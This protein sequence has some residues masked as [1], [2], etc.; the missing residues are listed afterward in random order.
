MKKT[1]WFFLL[2]LVGISGS[3]LAQDRTVSGKVTS[4]DDGSTIPGVT[5]TV[6]G[7]SKGVSTDAN[8][9][10]R[11]AVAD[12]AT[13]VFTS[14]GFDRKEVKVGTQ[15]VIDI[16]LTSAS[17]ALDEVVVIGYGV[18]KKSKLSS[19]ITKIDGKD[20]A[21]LSGPSF[22]QQ[23][24]GRAAG[25]QVTVG[26]GIVGQAPRIRIRGTNS[27]TSGGSPLIVI[28][29]VPAIDGNQS[30][31]TPTN[32][33][34]DIDPNDIESTEILKDGAA[35]AIYGSRA[36][37]GVILIT[38]KK[39][40]KG[41]PLKVSLSAQ[42]GLTNAVNRLDLLN[43]QQF[44]E[45]A[46]EKIKNAG[47]ATNQAFLD[48]NNTNTDWQNVILRQG[49]AQN[50]NVNFGGGTD[51]TNYYFSLGYSNIEGAVVSNS[52]KR[53]NF[54]SN[55]DHSFNKVLSI[56]TKLQITRTE[57]DGLNTGSNALSGNLTG[58]ARLFP[59]VPALDP[60]NATGFNL[61]PDGAVLG[62]GANTRGIDNNYTNLAF[63]LANNK[64]RAQIGRALSTT[65]LQVVPF[66]GLILKSQI[67]IDYADTRSFSSTDPRHGD[68]RGS[69]G[70]TTQTSRNVTRWNW[71]NTLNFLKDFGKHSFN[72]T[73]GLEYQKE[74]IST[75][76]ANA[77]NF[78]DRFFQAENIISGSFSVPVVTGG[79][80]NSGFDSY[81]G[82]LMYDY[83]N[84]YFLTFSARNDGL[85]SLPAASR[86]GNF[87]GGSVA[88]KLSNEEFYKN[89]G[90]SQ[91]INDIKLRGSYAQVG[92]TDIG[93]FPYLGQ[94][95]SA[96]YASQN[97][98]GFTQ[99][100]NPGLKWESSS[101]I[102]LGIDLGLFQNRM[103]LTAEYYNNDVSD[104]IL[105]APTPA[106]LGVPNNA[107]A[108]NV[109]SLYNRGFEFELS[110]EIIKKGDFMWAV[111]LNYSTQTNMVT[112]LNKGIDGKDQS[113]FPSSYHIIRVGEPVAS[114]Y[115]YQTAGVNPANGSP[116]FV[117]GDGRIVQRNGN[118]GVYSFYDAANPTVVTNTQGAALSSIDVADGGDRRVLGNTNPTWF[119]GFT[120]RFTWKGID[121]EIFTRFSGGNKI[122]NV[123]RQETLLNQDFN[124]NSTE[125][126]KRW[127]AEGQITDVP[128]TVLNGGNIINLNANATSRFIESGDFIRIQNIILGYSLPKDMLKK[129]K[130]GISNVRVFGQVQNAFTFTS[131][132][133]LDP[134]LNANGNVNQTFGL[135][136][137]TNP[138]FRVF[139]FG[140]NVGF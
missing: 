74:N 119:G 29:G 128:R 138:Q 106:S 130:L 116:L 117:K 23:L 24:A 127:T 53:Y 32:P 15:S 114:L 75:F 60:N 124:N 11:I 37:N 47:G 42:Y 90:I 107:I 83:D 72:A 49:V 140:V 5:V 65:Y 113:I 54:T 133:G 76:S 30:G 68:G 91:T 104:L 35:T 52:Q 85:S 135:D 121:L 13:L 10:Y 102:N 62:Q 134:E 111:D 39:G 34:A 98:V 17:S 97:G 6:K 55:I 59:N 36:T 40:K 125:I 96:Q 31:A 61:S 58:A 118:T 82:R 14:I 132:K 94:F 70:S 43:A 123:T 86:R 136:F 101:Q 84:K 79:A 1:L 21:N 137:N 16:V 81:F 80:V 109:G 8:G 50:Y 88:Y 112:G 103:T 2:V 78:S 20:V 4:S 122:M 26:S 89:L 63:V 3:A 67:G 33:L 93:S 25:T 73:V 99:A 69:N 77:S 71:Q 18:Q 9:I 45:I 28:D 12:Q 110:A 7:T 38:T 41:S 51:K 115:G 22:D 48:A 129:A 131:Y 87:F 64:F 44:V 126:L 108:R 19:S 120:N 66:D 27:I 92:N 56:G 100:G 57:N 105:N 95:G 139:T 46:N